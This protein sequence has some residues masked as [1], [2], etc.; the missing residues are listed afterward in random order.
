LIALFL[1]TP[2]GENWLT[3]VSTSSMNTLGQITQDKTPTPSPVR[4]IFTGD[5]MMNRGVESSVIKNFG[6]DFSKLFEGVAWFRDADIVFGN[7]EGPVSDIGNNVGSKYSFRMDPQVLSALSDAGFTIVSFANNHIGDWNVAAFNDTLDRLKSADIAQTGAG[8]NNTQAQQP[9][10]IEKNGMRIGFLSFS[11]VGPNWMQAKENS[12]GILLASDPNRIEFITQ[13]KAQVDF[14]I[15][16]YHWGEEYVP[17]T[18]RQKTLAETSIDAGAD[19]IIGHHPHVIQ[20]YTTYK[21]KFIFYSLGNFIFDQS[22]SPE[23]M[24]GLIV[25]LTVNP[26]GSY[27][28]I[29]LTTSQQGKTYQI[30]ETRPF[31]RENDAVLKKET[32]ATPPTCPTPKDPNQQNKWLFPVSQVAGLGNYVPSNLVII[33]SSIPTRNLSTHCLTNETITALEKMV[34]DAKKQNLSL[35]VSS[36]YRSSSI[37]QT[38]FANNQTSQPDQLF[39]TVAKPEH[40]EHQLGT[41]VDFRSGTSVEFT[42][43]GFTYSPEYTW[44][45]ENAQLYGFVQSYPEGK[46]SV[47]GYGAESWHWRYVGT[48]HALAIHDGDITAYEYLKDLVQ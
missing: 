36:A 41:A 16:S 20:D 17:F 6:H 19:L 9:T 47:T 2:F 24:R 28:A 46:E 3:A 38:L 5:I 39:P 25:D 1:K 13:A 7:L 21:D 31:E 42:L 37:Q 35:I 33:P 11:D 10:I 48:E 14:L 23:T 18:A 12:P 30:I 27:G 15:I 44:M 26:D 32:V 40:S 22:F 45:K 4:I 8:I 29:E 43:Q 34:T